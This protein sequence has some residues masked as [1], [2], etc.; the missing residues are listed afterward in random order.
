MQNSEVRL[1]IAFDKHSATLRRLTKQ[2][3]TE[4]RIP[5]TVPVMAEGSGGRVFVA[6]LPLREGFKNTVQHR[7]P[8]EW[9]EQLKGKNR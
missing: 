7:R 6:S 2:A 3:T 5:L 1:E 9:N 4:E 8:L